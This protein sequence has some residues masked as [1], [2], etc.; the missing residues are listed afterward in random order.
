M[1]GLGGWGRGGE[2]R[3]LPVVHM[4]V[5][6]EDSE[7]CIYWWYPEEGSGLG[8]HLGSQVGDPCGRGLTS[9]P[10]DPILSQSRCGLATVVDVSDC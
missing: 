5:L 2:E 10:S 6:L 9:V 1:K 8:S 3:R 4:P 7:E